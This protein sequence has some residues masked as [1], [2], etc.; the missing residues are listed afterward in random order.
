MAENINIG[1]RAGFTVRHI[2][3]YVRYIERKYPTK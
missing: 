1:F 2:T 3:K